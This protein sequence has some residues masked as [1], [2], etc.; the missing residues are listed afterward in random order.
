MLEGEYKAV[1]AGEMI[2]YGNCK[3]PKIFCYLRIKC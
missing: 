2:F 3:G 1:S